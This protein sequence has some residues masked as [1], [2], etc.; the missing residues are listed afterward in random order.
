MKLF[1]LLI[2]S[3]M[4]MTACAGW[5]DHE[6]DRITF[7]RVRP[8]GANSLAS[9]TM[10]PFFIATTIEDNI[11]QAWI[12]RQKTVIAIVRVKGSS[13]VGMEQSM[14][15]LFNAN[16]LSGKLI[17]NQHEINDLKNSFKLKKNWL[18]DT[19]ASE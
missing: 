3:G 5:P 9:T 2:L 10:K 13:K 18:T 15:Q 19:E 7:Y 1:W 12:N 16:N 17:T 8:Q 14:R 11:H 4:L 6:D